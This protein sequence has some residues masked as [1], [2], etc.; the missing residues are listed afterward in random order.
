MKRK[1][2]LCNILDKIDLWKHCFGDI[3][4]YNSL[5]KVVSNFDIVALN[6]KMSV[7]DS[8]K[9]KWINK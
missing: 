8:L 2:N 1:N 4:E 6:R 3:W 5:E 7:E 9:L